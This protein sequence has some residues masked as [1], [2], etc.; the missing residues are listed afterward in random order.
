MTFS[1][2]HMSTNVPQLM[3]LQ[4]LVH[5]P[6]NIIQVKLQLQYMYGSMLSLHLST[7]GNSIQTK[8]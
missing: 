7:L 8:Q 1:V 3:T 4:G 6:V 5:T 2:V